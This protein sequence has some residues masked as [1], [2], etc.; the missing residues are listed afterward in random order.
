MHADHGFRAGYE[1]FEHTADVGLKVRGRT[2]EELFEQA[3]A[4]FIDLMFETK[5]VRPA[6]S[7]DVSARGEESEDLLVAWL[8]EILFA[9]EVEGFV[10]VCAEV[11]SLAEQ[12][13]TGKLWGDDFDAAHHEVRLVVKAVTYHNLEIKRAGDG[14]EVSVVFD[15]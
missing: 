12:E 3:A 13:V 9:F 6:R 14:Y 10:A 1:A 4:G 11:E 2:M 7:V 8:Q 5:A 15:I